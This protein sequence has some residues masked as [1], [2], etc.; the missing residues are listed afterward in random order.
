MGN[1][2]RFFSF[3]GLVLLSSC[4]FIAH[5]EDIDIYT[6]GQMDSQLPNVIFV[7]DNVSNWSNNNQKFDGGLAQGE[8]EVRAIKDAVK[9]LVGKVNVGLFKFRSKG[10]CKGCGYVRFS[11]QP[12]T[13]DAQVE[14]NAILDKIFNKITDRDEA[15]SSAGQYGE[16]MLDLYNYLAGHQS[17]DG[18]DGTPVFADQAGYSVPYSRFK[19]P[20]SSSTLCTKTII[21]FVGNPQSKGPEIDS[22]ANSVVLKALYAS[23]GDLAPDKLSGDASGAPL[24]IRV[25]SGKNNLM[26]DEEDTKSGEN[27]NFDDWAKFFNLYGVPIPTVAGS[28]TERHSISTYTIDVYKDQPDART[29]GLLHSA[30]KV[31]GGRYFVASSEDGIRQAVEKSMEGVLAVNSSFTAA[32][33]PVQAND[34]VTR[35]NEVFLGV[36]R[37]DP[38][39]RPRWFGNLKKYQMAYVGGA[40]ALVDKGGNVATDGDGFLNQCA[41][42]WW[43]VGSGEYWKNL[44]VNPSPR[45]LCSADTAWS[46]APDGPFIEKGG[47]AQ[48][49]RA[50]SASSRDLKTVGSGGLVSLTSAHFNS[51]IIYKY[52]VGIEPSKD[53]IFPKSGLRA[54]VHGDVVHSSPT[55][56][57]YRGTTGTVVFY[58]SNDGLFRAVS[59]ANGAELW[60]LLA[61]EHIPK[62]QRLYDNAPLVAYPNQAP[63][64][65]PKDYFFDGPLGHIV[66]YK[67]D[68]LE[69][70]WIYPT[71]RRGGRMVYALNVTEPSSPKLLWRHGCSNDTDCTAGF[72]DIGQTWSKPVAA[73]VRDA[74]GKAHQVVIFGGGYDNCEDNKVAAVSCAAAKGKSVYVL[75]AES[76]QLIKTFTT[77]RSVAADVSVVDM[78][79][80]GIADYAYAADMGGAVYRISLRP[81]AGESIGSGW[82]ITKVA[83]TTGSARKFMHAPALVP[84][85]GNVYVALGSG[86][87]ERPLVTDYPYAADIDDRFYVFLDDPR[88]SAVLSLDDATKMTDVDKV[89]VKCEDEGIAVGR[90]WYKLLPRRGEQVANS[91]V[92][93]Q[94]DVLFS[95]YRPGGARPN[96]CVNGLGIGTDYRINLFNGSACGY[97]PVEGPGM[98]PPFTPPFIPAIPPC[99]GCVPLPA[100]VGGV[101][102]ERGGVESSPANSRSIKYW[103]HEIDE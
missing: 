73:K 12:F 62:L 3:L 39:A 64:A 83:Y 53:E 81:A 11:L 28:K 82:T 48:Q 8:S 54:S 34:K 25:F 49:L 2:D 77:D 7:L 100:L 44:G 67:D 90:G 16:F 40:L 93:F 10:D 65:R 76:G 84:F 51:D 30:A 102:G 35:E 94:G 60:G 46:D 78:N 24:P 18:G 86:N 96:M 97:A 75:H 42:S 58:G 47:S 87:R 92:V 59:G 52:F 61:P 22:G 101:G 23:V 21:V 26:T 74:S 50:R 4:A 79:G 41:T 66:N 57:N 45:G 89:V 33:I 56:I 29:S 38:L 17:I 6:S 31:G 99:E 37:P 13:A 14:F 27:W 63:E 98:P 20:F 9:G 43:T 95:T 103:V 85:K 71:M 55:A 88:G 70:A 68:K 5:A 19:S 80:D 91:A 72:S 32:A 15:R 69:K 1:F 36:F